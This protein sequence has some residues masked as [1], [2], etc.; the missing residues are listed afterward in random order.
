M[1][2]LLVLLLATDPWPE[3]P[4]EV[5]QIWERGTGVRTG[6]LRRK[7]EEL[8]KAEEDLASAKAT[9]LQGTAQKIRAIRKTLS[10]LEKKTPEL[11][12]EYAQLKTDQFSFTWLD[13]F[14]LVPGEIG[15]LSYPDWDP[16][17]VAPTFEVFQV[18]G[19]AEMLLRTGQR[20]TCVRGVPTKG[21]VDGARVK[22][23]PRLRVTSTT[24]YPT[25]VGGTNTVFVLEPFDMTEFNR[26]LPQL[27][28][29][30][31]RT[32]TDATGKHTTEARAKKVSE[33]TVVLE[34]LEGGEVELSLS[35]LSV[36]D[37]SF[38]NS[39]GEQGGT[40]ND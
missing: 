26:W 13:C 9:K 17:K 15:K 40:K 3:P 27:Q 6:R 18:L 38:L 30:M 24:T 29:T 31:W 22:I 23:E 4:A 39:T 28:K 12:R 7:Y 35:S 10:E 37:R 33:K 8:K 2:W 21:V 16:E 34:K 5:V 14:D 11:R 32:W 25:I 36:Q 1:V 20:I 19:Q